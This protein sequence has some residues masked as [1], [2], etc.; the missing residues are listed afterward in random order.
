MITEAIKEGLR[1][2]V[3][4]ILPIILAGLNTSTGAISVDWKV[5]VVV[6][7]VAVLRFV[8][9]AMHQYGKAITETLPGKEV[10][11]LEKGL[12]RF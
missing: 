8:D 9:S 3:L 6:A 11:A 10:S 4:S 1:V 12:V 5:V 7:I 2:V